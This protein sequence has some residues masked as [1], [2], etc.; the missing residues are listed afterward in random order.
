MND[1]GHTKTAELKGGPAASRVDAAAPQK[2]AIASVA[3]HWFADKGNE[4]TG[5]KAK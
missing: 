2:V 4:P 5:Q 3:V 1:L